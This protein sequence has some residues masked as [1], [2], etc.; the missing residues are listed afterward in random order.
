MKIRTL[1]YINRL[2]KEAEQKLNEYCRNERKLQHEYKDSETADNN[3]VKTQEAIFGVENTRKQHGTQ[4]LCITTA[5]TA[6]QR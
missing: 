5:P 4:I 1:E 2:L 6:E 3:L